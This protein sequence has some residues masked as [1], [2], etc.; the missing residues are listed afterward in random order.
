MG[1]LSNPAGSFSELFP[2]SV[3]AAQTWLSGEVFALFPEEARAVGNAVA[4]R[5]SEFSAGRHCARMAMAELG[6][7]ACAIPSG[8]DRAPVWPLGLVGSITHS[9]ELCAAVVA[10]S[11]CY[12]SVGIDTELID[13]IPAELVDDILRPDE[14][15]E[16]NRMARPDGADWPTL[17]FCLKEAAYK[18]FYPICRRIIGFQDMRLRVDPEARRFLA[19]LPGLFASGI[20]IFQGRYLVRH[21]RIH[22]ACW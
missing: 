9:A 14:A 2:R 3:G 21:G 11:D 16:I 18:A 7:L 5:R 12:R 6:H 10:R 20:P 13:A 1:R 22:A 19:E 8:P 4:K 15:G 17:Y